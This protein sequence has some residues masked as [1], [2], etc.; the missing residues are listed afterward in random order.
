MTKTIYFLVTENVTLNGWNVWSFFKCGS[1]GN[2]SRTK[3]NPI[4]IR[5]NIY[6]PSRTRG[7]RGTHNRRNV[8]DQR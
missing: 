8:S 1:A 7:I 4:E 3:K 5:N 2:S 6:G